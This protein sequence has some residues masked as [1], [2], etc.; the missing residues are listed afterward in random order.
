MNKIVLRFIAVISLLLLVVTVFSACKGNTGDETGTTVDPFSV[1]EYPATVTTTVAPVTP[2]A[3]S[4]ETTT[5]LFGDFA[6]T[7]KPA[8]TTQRSSSNTTSYTPSY[9][10]PVPGITEPTV[11][12]TLPPTV[13]PG[14]TNTTNGGSSVDLKKLLSAFGYAYDPDEDCFY[15]EL[16]SWQR[17]G[18]FAPHYDLGAFLLNMHYLT[19]TVDFDWGGESWRIQF[20]KGNYSPILDGAEIGIYTKP[21]GSDTTLYDTADDQHLL[22]MSMTLYK[23]NPKCEATRYF[24]RPETD[25]W[26]LTGFK[27]VD[28]SSDSLPGKMVLVASIRFRD[29][30]MA[31]AFCSSLEQVR[32]NYAPRYTFRLVPNSM[33]LTDECYHREGNTVT[34]CWRAVGWLNYD[35]PSEEET[36]LKK[37]D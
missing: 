37:A 4:T 27:L 1:T 8:T 13:D 25:H 21:L 10:V 36:Q 9:T 31:D 34:L 22:S 7:T 32:G 35:F 12:P 29:S 17:K 11:P 26:W 19:F 28:T 18:G 24:S 3:S 33:P 16:D 15:S 20:W 2:A 5:N 14:L 23:K 6:T 30:E